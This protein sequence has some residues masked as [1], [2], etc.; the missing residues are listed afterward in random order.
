[1]F[2]FLGNASNC[3][4]GNFVTILCCWKCTR[5]CLCKT[6]RLVNLKAERSCQAGRGGSV[7]ARHKRLLSSVFRCSLSVDSSLSRRFKL[8]VKTGALQTKYVMTKYLPVACFNV[9]VS[10]LRRGLPTRLCSN[11]RQPAV[12]PHPPPLGTDPCLSHRP[13]TGGPLTLTARLRGG[14]GGR[15]S[16]PSPAG[17]LFQHPTA[18]SWCT[19]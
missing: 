12:G 3:L 14:G 1:M 16:D 13:I 19:R 9:L 10:V 5:S 11:C 7:S 4:G 8:I 15:V 2:S 6:A 17:L 18:S